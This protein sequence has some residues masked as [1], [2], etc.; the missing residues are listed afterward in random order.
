MFVGTQLPP[1]EMNLFGLKLMSY[2]ARPK[3]MLAYNENAQASSA[4]SC[5]LQARIS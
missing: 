3:R 2:T 4:L 5:Q 1:T